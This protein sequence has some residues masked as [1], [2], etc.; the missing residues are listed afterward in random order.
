MKALVTSF[1]SHGFDPSASRE[2]PLLL[3]VRCGLLIDGDLPRSVRL[4]VLLDQHLVSCLDNQVRCP[5]ASSL[6]WKPILRRLIYTGET[7]GHGG[8]WV[9]LG[10]YCDSARVTAVIG[11]GDP[12]VFMVGCLTHVPSHWLITA[13]SR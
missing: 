11:V 7:T 10:V 2:K 8:V 9:H 12:P 6:P 5:T 13:V 3:K 1:G 4:G